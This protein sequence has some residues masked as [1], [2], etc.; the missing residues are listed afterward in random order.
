M[1]NLPPVETGLTV[2]AYHRVGDPETTAFD[3]WVITANQEQLEGQ[4]RFF[5]QH[6]RLVGLDE[7]IEIA[8][9]RD[10]SPGRAILITFDD[11]YLDNYQMALPVLKAVG[12]EATFFLV[13]GFMTEGLFAW[14][15]LMAWQ[16]RAAKDAVFQL[17]VG[18]EIKTVDVRE[19]SAPEA[20]GAVLDLYKACPAETLD[21]FTTSLAAAV[22]AGMQPPSDRMFLDMGEARALL[23]A[24]MRLGAHTQTHA[25]LARLSAEEQRDEMRR[26]RAILEERIGATI[27]VMAYPVGGPSD[28]D[29]TTQALAAECGYRAAF[30]CHGGRNEPGRTNLFDIKRRAVYWNAQPEHIAEG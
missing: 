7:A 28:F 10:K 27:D 5:Q 26:S 13:S 6:H 30:S 4:L 9:G 25:I 18:T 17:P 22:P 3:P 29:Q 20:I 23:D 12:C 21:A 19:M 8:A 24:G 16:I 2:L 11:G 15:D 14:W 1:D